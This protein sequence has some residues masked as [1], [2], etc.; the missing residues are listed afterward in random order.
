M[1]YAYLFYAQNKPTEIILNKHNMETTSSTRTK[2][3]ILE[4]SQMASKWFSQASADMMDAY[5]K[6]MNMVSDFYE[7]FSDTFFGKSKNLWNPVKFFTNSFLTGKDGGSSPFNPY[8]M[9]SQNAGFQNPFISSV[10][11]TLKLITENNEKIFSLIS[12]QIEKNTSLWNSFNETYQQICENR[13]NSFKNILNLL[14]ENYRKRLEFSWEEDAHLQEEITKEL[15]SIVK[16]NEKFW[17]D[18]IHIEQEIIHAA[19]PKNN[20]KKYAKVKVA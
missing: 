14:L 15:N 13:F 18:A 1:D 17:S 19:E 5:K 11:K 4:N 3:T 7:G 6:Q 9:L 20:E 10:E 8:F 2:E 16:Q 12:N